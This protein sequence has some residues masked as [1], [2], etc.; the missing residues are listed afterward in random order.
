MIRA[1]VAVIDKGGKILIARRKTKGPLEG[2]WE[3]P[4]G[5]IKEGETPDECIRREVH[6]ELGVTVS[7][8]GLLCST[9]HVYEHETVELIAFRAILLS[10]EIH[11]GVYDEMKWVSPGELAN[12]R[13]PEANTPLIEILMQRG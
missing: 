5:K 13:F 9:I 10:G 6:E 4:G 11:G 8:E 7:P 1:A 3:F 2:K 12:Y